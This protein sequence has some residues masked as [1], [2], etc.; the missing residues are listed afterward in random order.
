MYIYQLLIFVNISK[1]SLKTNWPLVFE[2][3][4]TQKLIK[5]L[6]H[7]QKQYRFISNKNICK[8]ANFN[9]VSHCVFFH[10]N[11]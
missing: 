9:G 5:N 10:I 11:L 4:K 2:N 1:T 6:I 7:H 3:I 8:T